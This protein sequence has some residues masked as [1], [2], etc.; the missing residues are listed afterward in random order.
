M[1]HYEVLPG[2]CWRSSSSSGSSQAHLGAAHGREGA[3]LKTYKEPFR[4]VSGGAY[5]I[6][7]AEKKG[8]T[9]FEPELLRP[10]SNADAVALI[11]YTNSTSMVA[12]L[13]QGAWTSSTR[14]RTTPSIR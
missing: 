7:K 14:C 3:G 9:V 6:T 1:I 13:Q 10:R 4:S 2:T 12:D 11:Y 8:T 5:I